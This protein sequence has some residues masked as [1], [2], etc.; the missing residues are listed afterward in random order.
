MTTSARLLALLSLL[1]ARRD[2]PGPVLAARLQVS[3]RTVR[4][5]VERLRAM[6]YRVRSSRGAEGGYRLEPGEELP[7]LLLDDEQAV[8]L[9]VALGAVATTG[10]QVEDAAARALA[11]VRQVMPARLR[12]RVD[13]IESASV[14]VPAVGAVA[15]EVLQAVAAAVRDR[16]VL[17]L[18]HQAPGRSQEPGAARQV[19]PHHVVA[20]AGR[21]YLLG[22]DRDRA[23]WR[24]FRLDRVRLRTPHGPRFEPR[25]VPGGDAASF[26][27]ARFK[28]S[29]GPDAWPCQGEVVLHRPAAQVAPFVPDG[30]VEPLDAARCRV[31]LGSWSWT[32]LAS[33]LGRFDA[34]LEV[35]GPEALRSACD[36]LAARL[37]RAAHGRAG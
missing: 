22:W 12:H 23:D 18:D 17:R 27:A 24:T 36:D 32:G 5:D 9:A 4:R 19:E 10:V 11:T 26:V 14:A 30:I 15:P 25:G 2:W 34:E 33:S 3:P 28:G 20:R 8:A 1:Q 16:H 31:R 6:G 37:A 21:W 35:V 13:A 7:P 29:S